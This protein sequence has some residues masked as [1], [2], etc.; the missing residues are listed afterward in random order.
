MDISVYEAH[1]T[2]NCKTVGYLLKNTREEITVVLSQCDNEDLNQCIT[3][4]KAWVR[5]IKVLRRGNGK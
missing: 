1:T 2:A 5:K 4:P 3:I